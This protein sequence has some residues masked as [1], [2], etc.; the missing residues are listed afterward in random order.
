M[1]NVLAP[2]RGSSIAQSSSAMCRKTLRI[3]CHVLNDEARCGC[4]CDMCQA[5]EKSSRCTV[6]VPHVCV[7][8]AVGSRADIMRC[9]SAGELLLRIGNLVAL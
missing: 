9:I 7:R 4:R 3:L 5:A 6:Y 8:N 1:F 2:H